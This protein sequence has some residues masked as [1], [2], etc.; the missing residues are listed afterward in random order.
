M[1]APPLFPQVM[2]M[3][4]MNRKALWEKLAFAHV[5][6]GLTAYTVYKIPV[7]GRNI[8]SFNLL[9][10]CLK[11]ITEYYFSLPSLKKTYINIKKNLYKH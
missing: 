6:F 4:R 5:G 10:V 2:A 8:C 7:T 3:I 1:N 11:V 9:L